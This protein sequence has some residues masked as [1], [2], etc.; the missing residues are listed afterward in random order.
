ML[1]LNDVEKP[2]IL[3]AR[4]K[5]FTYFSD[6]ICNE[7]KKPIL[8]VERNSTKRYVQDIVNQLL[9]VDRETEI[10]MFCMPCD[11]ERQKFV[12]EGERITNVIEK[13]IANEFDL[14]I[15]ALE[16]RMNE[17]H[18]ALHDSIVESVNRA[19]QSKTSYASAAAYGGARPRDQASNVVPPVLTVVGP[20]PAPG[21]V[22]GRAE[23][24]GGA[25]VEGGGH[26]ASFGSLGHENS[27]LRGRSPSVKRGRGDSPA[28][29]ANRSTSRPPKQ[30]KCVIGTSKNAVQTSRQMR[31]PLQ[32]YSCGEFTLRPLYRISLL[33]LLIVV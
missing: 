32:I 28:G 26:Q 17:K 1:E 20:P 19:I 15:K 16:H 27:R 8:E 9:K 18:R 31:S 29:T 5:L 6:V 11:Y 13:E 4:K 7:R 22:H 2:E 12:S 23:V 30:M 14:K 3:D 24:H 25:A 10:Q 21:V 33:T